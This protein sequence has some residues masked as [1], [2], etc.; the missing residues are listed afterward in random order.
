MGNHGNVCCF[1]FQA[2][3][4][5][6]T[7]DGGLLVSPSYD[8]HQR[9]KKLRWYGL[10]RTSSAS[11]RCEQDIA[12]WGLKFHMNDVAATIGL[13]NFPASKDVVARH[14]ENGKFYDEALRHDIRAVVY[15]LKWNTKSRSLV[16]VRP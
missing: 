14:R 13:H 3:K 10:D 6:T 15:Q 16:T 2:I 7:V 8:I 9:A 12:E 4:H 11:F 1:S 5:F